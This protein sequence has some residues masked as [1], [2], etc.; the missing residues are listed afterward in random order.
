[1]V[2]SNKEKLK[3]EEEEEEEDIDQL[4]NNFKAVRQIP[5]S[6]SILDISNL[7]F[8]ESKALARS[9]NKQHLPKL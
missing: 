5:N 3:E 2:T 4:P 9:K 1:M 6:L 7:S 8:T